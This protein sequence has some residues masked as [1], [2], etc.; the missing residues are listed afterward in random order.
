MA[1]VG[2]NP[3]T[4]R[5]ENY[6]CEKC[7]KY[8]ETKYNSAM[9]E[10]TIIPCSICAMNFGGTWIGSGNM[11]GVLPGVCSVSSIVATH[12]QV[13]DFSISQEGVAVDHQVVI[14]FVQFALYNHLRWDDIIDLQEGKS[15]DRPVCPHEGYRKPQDYEELHQYSHNWYWWKIIPQG[16]KLPKRL[17]N[18][19]R[20][21]LENFPMMELICSDGG[22]LVPKNEQLQQIFDYIP[23]WRDF[24]HTFVEPQHVAFIFS[25][26]LEK[27]L[28]NGEDTLETFDLGNVGDD[29][30]IS[31]DL[32]YDSDEIPWEICQCV[33]WGGDYYDSILPWTYEP[34]CY[35]FN[36]KYLDINE[37]HIF[38][39]TLQEV[40]NYDS[41]FRE[42]TNLTRNSF[43]KTVAEAEDEDNWRQVLWET[44][45]F[46]YCNTDMKSFWKLPH[47][48]L[49]FNDRNN[50]RPGYLDGVLSDFQLEFEFNSRSEDYDNMNSGGYTFSDEDLPEDEDSETLQEKKDKLKEIMELIEGLK[51]KEK[52]NEGEYLEITNKMKEMF[53]LL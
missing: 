27:I 52:M 45:Y 40:I 35:K 4:G 31:N 18:I 10:I 12:E 43:I 38:G 14:G 36:G 23:S 1:K 7:Q 11:N 51:E 21:I 26:C 24:W 13:M 9:E 5:N 17:V 25:K 50:W 20:Q 49:V 3:I 16:T 28:N 39:C 22:I 37:R 2:C 41:D 15:K 29:A 8:G 48:Y 44:R 34:K 19:L 32:I 30:Y 42:I 46:A 47:Y 53:E 6:Y 33:E